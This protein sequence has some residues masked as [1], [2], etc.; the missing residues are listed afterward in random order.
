M[1]EM[2]VLQ[3][4]FEKCSHIGLKFCQF[5]CKAVLLNG[6]KNCILWKIFDE[7]M[8][9]QAVVSC[10]EL[11]EKFHVANCPNPPCPHLASHIVEQGRIMGV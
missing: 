6:P 5:V 8:I 11:T 1:R 4:I 7:D 10:R 2:F 3:F 9:L